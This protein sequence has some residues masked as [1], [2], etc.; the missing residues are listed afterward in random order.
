[1]VMVVVVVAAGAA[2]TW[3]LKSARDEAAGNVWGSHQRD[4]KADSFMSDRKYMKHALRNYMYVI[5]VCIVRT[6]Q[7]ETCPGSSSFLRL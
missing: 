4:G 2:G 3:M 5:L 1:M 6:G 7:L